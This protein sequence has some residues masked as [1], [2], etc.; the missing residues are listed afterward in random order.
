MHF[1]APKTLS[2]VPSACANDFNILGI[3]LVS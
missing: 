3:R 2:C 1:W